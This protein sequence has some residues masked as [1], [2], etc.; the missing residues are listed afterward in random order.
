MKFIILDLEMNGVARSTESELRREIIEIGAVAL[1]EQYREIGSY[2]TYVKPDFNEGIEEEIQKLTG[3]TTG[4]VENAPSFHQALSRFLEWLQSLRD[5]I[6]LVEWS[7]SDRRQMMKEIGVK[8]VILTEPH[9]T[10]LSDWYDLQREFGK[11]LGLVRSVSLDNALMYAGD[12][13]KGQQHDALS[14]ARNTA[15][16]FAMIRDPDHY[17]NELKRVISYLKPEPM[18]VSLGDLFNLEDLE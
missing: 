5:D 15:Y 2:M 12:N 8:G 13:F 11:V 18:G 6:R 9:Q 10:L 14:D 3:I 7:D 1:D 4:M 17:K 16:L